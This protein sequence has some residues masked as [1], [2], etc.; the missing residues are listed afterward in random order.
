M[1]SEAKRIKILTLIELAL[2]L[3]LLVFGIVL[4]VGGGNNN[5]P[6][7]LCGEG[8]IGL[9]FGARGAIIANVPARMGKLVSLGAIVLLLQIA[10]VIGII[11]LTDPQN[12]SQDPAPT[13]AA[14]IPA[15]I[16]LVAVLLARGMTKRAER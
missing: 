13:C 12:V 8:V 14:A 2:G 9:F 5:A 6:F 3:A 11:M 4:I 16:T 15:V 10:C 7:V 1:S